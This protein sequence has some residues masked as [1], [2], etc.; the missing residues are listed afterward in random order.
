MPSGSPRSRNWFAEGGDAYSRFRP[1]YP[2][3]LASFL[4]SMAPGKAL[5]ID[6]GCGSGQLTARHF[7]TAGLPLH[8]VCREARP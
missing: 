7:E 6:V 5:A 8:V 4:A 2:A 3:E 1:E